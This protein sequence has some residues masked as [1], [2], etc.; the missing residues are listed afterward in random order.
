MSSA[1]LS[2]GAE[3]L[4]SLRHMGAHMRQV[5]EQAGAEAQGATFS[6]EEVEGFYAA[7]LYLVNQSDLSRADTV[8][9]QVC[10]LRPAETRYLH[11]LA[12]I[13]QARGQ[14]ESAGTLLQCL[15]LLEPG[16]PQTALE[17]AECWLASG[18]REKAI[19]LID[20]TVDYCRD[21]G[22]SGP[23]ADRAQ[24]L[25]KLLKQEEVDDARHAPE[26]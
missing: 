22:I 25:A 9:T 24:A 1:T 20:L 11:T 16:N 8:L 13:R 17:L 23:D 3:T 4:A 21:Q 19:A 26:S 14:Y 10:D 2:P 15:D 6:D 18:N 12:R 7:G 5:I